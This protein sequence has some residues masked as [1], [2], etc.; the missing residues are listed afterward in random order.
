MTGPPYIP[1]DDQDREDRRKHLELI[2]NIV[3]RLASASATIKGWAITIAGAAFGVG[4]VRDNWY[5]WALGILVVLAFAS[6]DIHYLKTERDF[7]DLHRSVVANLMPPFC[8]TTS[9]VPEHMRSTGRE[10]TWR[11]WSVWKFYGPLI[12][13]GIIL[14]GA[15]LFFPANDDEYAAVTDRGQEQ[16][17]RNDGVPRVDP[18]TAFVRC[19]A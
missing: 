12:L 17:S 16:S 18:A 10:P 14:A 15:S 9:E 19:R 13:G 7:R 11:S 3:S 6:L 4:A 5:L 2:Q 8:L 1:H